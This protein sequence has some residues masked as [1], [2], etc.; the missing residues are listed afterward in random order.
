MQLTRE[1]F[2]ALACAAACLLLA[3]CG[4]GG[5]GGDS[6]G[7]GL[8]PFP[9]E[10][11]DELP[12]GTRI[13][14]SSKNLFEM[15]SG[16]SWQYTT[17]DA[18]G[19]PT[20]ATATRQ[21][22]SGPDGAGHVSLTDNDGGAVTTNYLVSADG[23]LDP[24]P[25][26]GVA[27]PAAANI[28]GGLFEYAT[29]LYPMGAVR[30]HVRSGPWGA[31]LDG[32][33]IGESFRFEFTQVFLGFET[34]KLSPVFTLKEVA[35]FHNVLTLT[36]RPTAA[37]NTDYIITSTEDTWFAPGFGM[38]RAQR[39]TVD[40]DGAILEPQH[41][42][43][44]SQ[45]FVAGVNWNVSAPPPVIDGTAID[46]PVANNALVYDSVRGVYYA[47]VSA[48]AIDHPNTIATIDPAGH[49]SFSA[50]LPSEPNALAIAADASALYVGADETGDVVKL[51]LP[52]M[53]EVART[54]LPLDSI[55]GEQTVAGAITVSPAD[56]TVIAVSMAL[57][58][59]VPAHAG[60]ALLR[61]MVLQPKVTSTNEGLND[62]ITFDSAGT[63]LYAVSNES[64]DFGLRRFGVLADGL[65][66][67]QMLVTASGF[68]GADFDNLA[69]TFV[70]GRVISGHTLYN[71][72]G[73]ETSGMV[74]TESD[75]KQQRSGNFLYCFDVRG[76]NTGPA[77]I[78]VA[79]A[80]T[81]VI[82]ASL[83]FAVSEPG[84][85]RTLV[86]GPA[87]QLAIGYA[88][89]DAF[90]FSKVRLF[91][92]A[93]LTAPPAPP[94]PSWPITAST[95][96]DGQALDI[97][98]V[99]N[100][101]V[102][103]SFR[104]VYFASV[105]GSVIGAG[106]SMA[107][108]DP[109]TGQVTHSAPIGSE[110]NQL[111][112]AADGS[113]LYVGL[114]GSNEVARFAL[115]SMTPQGRT[116]L[117]VDSFF[118]RTRAES[119][120]ISP[121]DPSVAAVAMAWVNFV[122]PHH[123]GNALLRDMVL[124]P[125]RTPVHTGSN[126]ITFDSTGTKVYGINNEGESGLRRLGVLSDGLVEELKVIAGPGDLALGFMSFVNG[127][128][129]TRG[130]LY[131]APD[132]TLAGTVA[133]VGDCWPTRSGTLLLCAHYRA[134]RVFLA[135]PTTFGIVKSLIDYPNGE[136]DFARSLVQGPAGQIGLSYIPNQFFPPS[137]RLF[138][139]AQLP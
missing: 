22:T 135:D 42:L 52:S 85:L 64:T 92:S 25:L 109:A 43:V 55:L 77:H 138:T 13:D 115:P 118:G 66:L 131:D 72:P 83:G 15:G 133:G 14:V 40:S 51:A 18:A 124:Q 101:L 123:A 31:D 69:L 91:T 30:S 19:T 68:G 60:L 4:G 8:T 136:P 49:V 58:S 127:Q 81:F 27:P 12:S 80:S 44:F 63:K 57:T 120:A 10:K 48:F 50:P 38:A 82:Q 53:V 125:K 56:P 67:E 70:N 21:V 103:D 111:A 74:S 23:L 32:D 28:I 6:G 36:L 86:E 128:V 76:T 41:T 93:Q 7:N 16:D 105:P 62:L 84:G 2:C 87:G 97:G 121:V 110:P 65:V 108:I 1:R 99:H 9:T 34:L 117:I 79:D 59:V 89:S 45:G 26:E 112:L 107:I 20:G 11:T 37:G 90:S 98:I 39:S 96:P 17:L 94:A 106:N 139:S 134:G 102:Y 54:R 71:A 78:L 47:S 29:P 114:D 104:N 33:G 113:V 130:S 46:V 88:V 122:D 35:H 3:A 116:R 5:G 95:T 126:L 119:I 24:A 61:D 100:S 75:C 129:I 73:L 137:I 132:L